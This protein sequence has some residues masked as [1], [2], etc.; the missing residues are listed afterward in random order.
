MTNQTRYPY[1]NILRCLAILGVVLIHNASPLVNMTWIRQPDLWWFGNTANAAFRFAVPVFLMLSGATLLGREMP[2][3]DFYK[4][5]YTKVLLP[6]LFWIP[7]YIIFRW[8]VLRPSL[9]PHDWNGII[10]FISDLWTKDGIS[11][12]FWYIWMILFLYLI[13]PFIGKFVR[14]LN[15]KQLW[16]ILL[17]WILITQFS[18]KVPLNPY[19]WSGNIAQKF[20]GY[21]L[22]IGYILMGYALFITPL[23]GRKIRLFALVTFFITI[24]IAVFGVW[25]MSKGGRLNQTFHGYLHFNTILQSIAIFLIFKD[26]QIRNKELLRFSSHL[27]D[28]SYGIYLSH[29]IIIGTLFYHGIYWKFAHPLISIPLLTLGVLFASWLLIWILRKIRQFTFMK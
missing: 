20:F 1:L 6:F 13:I 3:V 18:L 25:M 28:Y 19:G 29:M 9:Q 27:S 2:L 22:Y 12:H 24:I 7:A 17:I 8:L 26:I 23:N 21:S 11:K 4:R 14:N 10:N 16:I 15:L 5:R